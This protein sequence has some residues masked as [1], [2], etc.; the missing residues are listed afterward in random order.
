MLAGAGHDARNNF[1]AVIL[2]ALVLGAGAILST[3]GAAV[4]RGVGAA[5]I[6]VSLYAL[7]L[8]FVWPYRSKKLAFVLLL[9]A[10]AFGAL[11]AG[12]VVGWYFMSKPA[13][14]TPSN[15]QATESTAV[16]HLTEL[17]WTVKPTDTGFQFEVADRGLPSMQ[18][19]AEFFRQLHRPFRLTL[20]RVK[21]LDG[22]H[23]LANVPGCTKIEIG[24]GEFTDISELSG[25]TSLTELVIGQVPLNGTGIVDSSPLSTLKEL[26][27]LAL[28]NSRIRSLEFARG[29]SKLKTLWS[30]PPMY[31]S[32]TSTKP[33]S[34]RRAFRHPLSSK[35]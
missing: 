32:S 26:H 34:W 6:V 8:W 4:I 33:I 18:E 29:L 13:S 11:C 20:Q 3:F 2:A 21:S 35:G 1:F 14:A 31:V 27:S 22:L 15:D 24:A 28:S 25:F 23:Y 7:S 10:F 16:A 30:F 9:A 12:S 17:G 19:S 5:L